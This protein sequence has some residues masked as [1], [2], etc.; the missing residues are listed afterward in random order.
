MSLSIAAKTYFLLGQ[1]KAPA[2]DAELSKLAS[3]FGWLVGP[4]QVRDATD[5]LEKLGLVE[6]VHSSLSPRMHCHRARI[7]FERWSR[8]GKSVA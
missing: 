3:R 1:K 6:P 8:S 5:Y 4:G 7:S 2:S